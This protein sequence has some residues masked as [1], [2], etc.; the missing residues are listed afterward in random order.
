MPLC[1]TPFGELNYSHNGIASPG[2]HMVLLHGAGGERRTWPAT[3]RHAADGA[4][5]IGL[6][7]TADRQRIINHSIYALDLPGHGLSSGKACASVPEYADAVAAFLDAMDLRD[8]VLAG[9]SMGGAIALTCALAGTERLAGLVIVGSSARLGVTDDILNGL[10]SDFEKT[11]GFIVK[12]SF[13]RN[14]G[15]FFPAKAREYML[16]A[17]SETVHADFF[18]CSRYDV[19]D[20]LGEITLPTLV[21]AAEGDRL[22]PFKH[23]QALA[24]A[25]P[26]AELVA[27]QDCG[28]FLHLERTTLVERPIA[29]FLAD[30]A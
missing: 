17:G 20:R 15:P 22:V 7:R 3:W 24:G 30:L 28:H 1:E 19:R 4:R 16:A 27:F 29:R 11:V 6:A 18:A 13:D 14:G 23:S 8:V 2:P 10:Q 26:N 9:H 5:A 25:L 12:N 21:L